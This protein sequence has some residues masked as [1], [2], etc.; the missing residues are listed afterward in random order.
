[1]SFLILFQGCSTASKESSPAIQTDQGER[2]YQ[3]GVAAFEMWRYDVALDQFMDSLRWHQSVE[4]AEG[5]LKALHAI[6]ATF[7]E[8]EDWNAAL[9]SIQTAIRLGQISD[10]SAGYSNP[11]KWRPLWVESFWIRATIQARTGQLAEAGKD[12]D[13]YTA[14]LKQEKMRVQEQK[15]ANLR[16]FIALYENQTDQALNYANQAIQLK[17]KSSSDIRETATAWQ[18]LAEAQE[19]MGDWE[20]AEASWTT[21]LR[22]NREA[23]R[24]QRII[25]ALEGLARVN[26]SQ[27]QTDPSQ[28][29]K[30][31]AQ[32][33]RAAMKQP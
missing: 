5:I 4:N 17:N 21:T 12:L 9:E 23:G 32:T 15:I 30:E 24:S 6:T 2:A 33:I 10:T 22:L 8:K 1:M 26:E 20:A 16:S 18:R 25:T 3:T 31:R 27:G 14:L 13:A 29:F 7:Q 11:E 19:A 28:R